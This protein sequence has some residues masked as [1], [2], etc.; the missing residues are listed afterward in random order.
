MKRVSKDEWLSA[1]LE[2]L[3]TGGVDAVRIDHLAKRL[4]ISRS[5]FYWHFKDRENLLRDIL[6]YWG[7]EYNK[8]VVRRIGLLKGTPKERLAKLMEMIE[9]YDL[10]RYEIAI[11]AWARHDPLA[12]DAV[13]KVNEVRLELIRSLFSEMGFEADELEMRTMLFVCYH[14]WEKPMF[15]DIPQT[16]LAKLRKLRLE[17]LTRW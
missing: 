9:E 10:T 1:A 3:E 6:Q 17:F 14:T 5:G 4:R 8:V 15:L 7:D 16:K 12:R 2:A 13:A 11:R